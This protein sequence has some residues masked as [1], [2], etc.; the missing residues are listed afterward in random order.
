M[1]TKEQ[2]VGRGS[3]P[4]PKVIEGRYF[5]DLMGQ[6]QALQETLAGLEV[7]DKLRRLTPVEGKYR[8]VVL[9]GMGASLNA[10]QPL[11]LSLLACG[12]SALL[13]E[14]SELIHFL[15]RLLDEST[16]VIAVS[17][18]GKSAETVKLLELP[19]RKSAVIGVTN[20]ADSPLATRADASLVTRAGTEFSVSCKTYVSALAALAWLG[21]LLCGGQAGSAAA[22][23][24]QAAGL[25]DEY[26]RGWQKHT[27]TLMTELEGVRDL[28]FLGRG[29]SLAAA[30]N[31]GLITKESTRFHSEGMSSAA[32]RH[33]PFEM[34]GGQVFALVYEGDAQV[35]RL[36]RGLVEDIRKA[37]GRAFL[38]GPHA[39]LQAFQ[40]PPV[41]ASV[42]PI[43]EIL[44]TQMI[45]LALA[46]LT[47]I[48]AGKF[49]KATKVTE[50]E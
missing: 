8:R 38:C 10:L 4:R 49:R 31:S 35:E 17:Q 32:F 23:L 1:T 33:G 16:L 19:G 12:T 27:N 21:D 22:E 44:P 28:F 11:Y 5:H 18:S 3:L 25:V 42:R 14:T 47:G 6:P 13:V 50:K 34:V 30:M 48:E 20:G 40:L 46:A 26:L 43:L 45:T 29:S 39:D 36:N 2:L 9:T 24:P 7:S 37:G 15:A 41:P